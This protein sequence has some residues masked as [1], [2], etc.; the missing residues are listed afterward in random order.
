MAKKAE[1]NKL[2]FA[3]IL[4]L[5]QGERY[6]LYKSSVVNTFG[7]VADARELV[8]ES[9]HN[10][11]KVTAQLKRDYT[12]LLNSGDL[13]ADTSETKYFETYCGGNVPA[14]VK[15]LATFANA[16]RLETA[17]P[18]IPEVI[19]DAH[20]IN[21]L[22]KAAPIIAHERKHHAATW[23]GTQN[24]LDVIA[25]LTSPGEVTKKLAEIRKRQKPAGED[26]DEA[27][28]IPTST[29]VQ[30]L[31]TRIM[32]AQNDDA[33][34]ALFKGA[35]EIADAWLKNPTLNGTGNNT[36]SMWYEHQEAENKVDIV[37]AETPAA[38]TTPAPA[39]ALAA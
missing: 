37:N 2:T 12:A 16:I 17:T 3:Q 9:L 7:K 25:A 14:R 4:A 24:T 20:S 38:E 1:I 5:P 6:T 27:A 29:L 11:M 21:T 30:L 10:A 39:E 34:Y 18:M 35:N 8:S 19:I 22:E 26:E 36:I 28:P 32:E 13:A 15:Q 31:I 33:G 23:E